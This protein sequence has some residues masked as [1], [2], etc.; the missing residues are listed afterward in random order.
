MPGPT[1]AVP[2]ALPAWA[3]PTVR[4]TPLAPLA[5]A[6]AAFVLL[7][8]VVLVVDGSPEPLL[9][10][11]AAATAAALVAGLHDPAASLL[12][13]MPASPARR[14]LHRLALLVPLTL[15]V[16]AGMLAAAQLAAPDWRS[17]WPFGPVTALACTAVAVSVW[18]PKATNA[19]WGAAAPMLWFALTRVV[20]DPGGVVGALLWAWVS[21][22]WVVVAVALAAGVA[23]ARR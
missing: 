9:P 8:T 5:V 20:G 15:L 7:G 1:A 14:L 10:L 6:A 11:A 12:A 16:W 21:D 22:P 13:A 2:A 18:A 17:G 19:A 4:A 23:G 3:R